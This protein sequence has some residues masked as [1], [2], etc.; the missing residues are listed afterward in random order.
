MSSVFR[1]IQDLGPAGVVVQAILATAAANAL[2]LALIL[3]RRGW[4]AR[5]FQRRDARARLIRGMWDDILTGA[6]P[7]SEW[8]DDALSREIV[9]TILLDALEFAEGEDA[10]LLA[11][12]L[13]RSGLLDARILE[14]RNRRG[15][16]RRRA[17][18]ALGR[19]RAIE[20]IPALAEALPDQQAGNALAAVRGLS[21]LG[22]PEAAVPLLE[23]LVTSS[24]P[25]PSSP[26][27]NALF[28]C[29]R[30]RPQV[31]VPYVRRAEPGLRQ[32]LARVLGEIATGDLDED[33]LLLAC[34]TQAEVRASASRALAEAPLDTA[35]P[36]LGAL[37][38]DDEWFVRL[39]AIVALGQL[40]HP[41]AIPSL[42]D[43]ACDSNRFVRLRAAMGLAGM[44]DQLEQV[45]D[46]VEQKQDL[47][48]MQALLSQMQASGAILEQIDRL[49]LRGGARE[50]AERILLRVVRLGACRLLV[51]VVVEHRDRNVRARLARLL[52]RSGE[53]E[54][55]P[56]LERALSNE[57]AGPKRKLIAKTLAQLG[58]TGDADTSTAA[59][60]VEAGVPVAKIQ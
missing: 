19:M 53:T 11:R 12:C 10:A 51:S 56:L 4:R 37:A 26:V 2:L 6:V 32:L 45:L 46:L 18:V 34:D 8:R 47:Y 5:V 38:E 48:A 50:R 44:E 59:G 15:I 14:A 30:S 33:L 39:R 60:A 13:R 40:K 1:W 22:L 57:T 42:V 35:L 27:Q 16:T 58:W 7:A 25:L 28:I 52:G 24:V 54:L 9:E 20:A 3:I 29:C 41:R 31:L 43:G 21:R 17:L 49:R 36:M 23:H 55:V